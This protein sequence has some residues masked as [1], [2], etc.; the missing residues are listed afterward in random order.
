MPKTNMRTAMGGS[1]GAEPLP[2]NQHGW[3]L[4]ELLLA[5]ALLAIVAAVVF[6]SFRATVSAIDQATISGAPARQARV[7]LSRLADELASADWAYERPETRFVGLS[8]E[9]EGH[10]SDRLQFSSRSHVWYPTQL[11]ALERALITYEAVPVENGLQLWRRESAAPYL[12]EGGTESVMVAE[13][14]AGVAFRFF[15]KGEWVDD[16]NSAERHALPELVEVVLT[17]GTDDTATEEF[18]TLID[19]PKRP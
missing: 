18:R 4:L 16:W 1:G 10:E 11:P 6:G 14:V 13:G 7:V 17:F 8:Q 9:L 12:L 2:P 3:T 19:I 15:V 5:V